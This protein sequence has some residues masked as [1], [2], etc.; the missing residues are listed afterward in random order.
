M[1]PHQPPSPYDED[2]LEDLERRLLWARSRLVHEYDD[3]SEE[4]LRPAD[5]DS[6]VDH[7]ADSASDAF[8]QEL[9]LDLL[10]DKFTMLHAIEDALAR[11]DGRGEYAYGLCEGCA[12][13]P[14]KLCAT[15]PWIAEARLKYMPWAKHCVAVQELIEKEHA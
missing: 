10:E 9:S 13:E 1:E 4:A 7:P 5:V 11:I 6:T 15:C 8:E 12:E 3:L 2:L 14:K